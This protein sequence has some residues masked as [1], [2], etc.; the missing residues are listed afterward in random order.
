MVGPHLSTIPA[1]PLAIGTMRSYGLGL[2]IY[3]LVVF[4]QGARRWSG[5]LYSTAVSVAPPWVWGLTF[6]TFGLAVLVGSLTYRFRLRNVGLYGSAV[7][8]LYFGVTTEQTALHLPTVS[9]AAGI[10]YFMVAAAM[11][12]VAPAREV[13]RAPRS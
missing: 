5:P 1:T 3:G 11:C 2:T 10:V 9:Y 7:L 12:W 4:G 6:A 8:Y 13:R